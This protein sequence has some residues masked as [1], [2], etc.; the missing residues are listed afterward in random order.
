MGNPL[1]YWSDSLHKT[2]LVDSNA[3]LLVYGMGE[4]PITRIVKEL[5]GGRGISGM[6]DVPQTAFLAEKGMVPENRFADEVRLFSHEECLKD[7]LKQAKNFKIVEEQSNRM[8]AARILQDVEE[9]TL[10]VNPPFPDG[11][12]EIDASFDLPYTRLPHPRYKE[13]SI[14]LRDDCSGQSHRGCFGGCA[15]CT[16]YRRTREV[17]R[18]PP[19]GIDPGGG[20]QITRCLDS[21]VILRLGG[22]S[23][24]M[25]KMRA[26][27]RSAPNKTPSCNFPPSAQPQRR[28]HRCW[29]STG[30]STACRASGNHSWAVASV[31]TCCCIGERSRITGRLKS[32]PGS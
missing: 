15:F 16:I 3:D 29:I 11:E 5:Q 17:H 8:E 21:R 19:E 10:V 24:N 32:I 23:A 26:T 2:I 18:F 20:E 7:K 14:G 30:R 27:T 25:Y 1:R 31:T 6:H 22:P 4:Q 28:P 13:K 9:K 12:V